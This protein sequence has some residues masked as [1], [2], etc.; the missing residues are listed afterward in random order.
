MA[1]T[2]TARLRPHVERRLSTL[3]EL[4]R[5]NQAMAG[6][7]GQLIDEASRGG[8]ELRLTRATADTVLAHSGHCG[9]TA[10]IPLARE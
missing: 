3:S 2:C 5:L 6:S 7:G 1:Q 9:P 4:A 8:N 10:P